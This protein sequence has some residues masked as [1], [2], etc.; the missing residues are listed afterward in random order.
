MIKAKIQDKEGIPI[1]LQRLTYAS[2]LLDDRESVEDCNI[3]GG[4][5]LHL[6]LRLKGGG[7]S[8]AKA[9]GSHN[10]PSSSPPTTWSSTI[11]SLSQVKECFQNGMLPDEEKH[12][13]T[14]S[15]DEVT[16][17]LIDRVLQGLLKDTVHVIH[18]GATWLNGIFAKSDQI[19]F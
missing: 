1:A 12:Y 2:R 11:N 17:E 15:C 3:R 14:P 19:A 13:N 16:G 10:N 9:A 8:P 7:N 6:L 4:S 18:P 5:T